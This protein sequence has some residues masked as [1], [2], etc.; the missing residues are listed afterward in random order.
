MYFPTLQT[1]RAGLGASPLLIRGIPKHL[2]P[3]PGP[4]GFQPQKIG[5]ELLLQRQSVGLEEEIGPNPFRL[6]GIQ[7]F[8]HRMFTIH[9]KHLPSISTLLVPAIAPAE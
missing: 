8:R 1:V 7:R 3:R 2:L 9:A 6:N 5:L 4:S